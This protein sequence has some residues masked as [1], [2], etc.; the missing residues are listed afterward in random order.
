MRQREVISFSLPPEG[1]RALKQAVVREGVKLS[2][3]LRAAV[4]QK[5]RML[6]W[7]RIRRKGAEAAKKFRVSPEDLESIVDEYRD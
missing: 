4:T 1:A 6:E 3:F 7:K 2:E 5:I